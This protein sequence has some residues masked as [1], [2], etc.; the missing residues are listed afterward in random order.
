MRVLGKCL[1]TK[2]SLHGVWIVCAHR[3]VVFRCHRWNNVD[4]DVLCC[5]AC[6]AVLAITYLPGLSTFAADKVTCLYEQQL[7]SEHKESCPF[8]KD[9]LDY[10]Q[11]DVSVTIPRLFASYVPA[12]LVHL[13]ETTRPIRVFGAQV[14]GRVAQD[15][16]WDAVQLELHTSIRQYQPPAGADTAGSNLA[17]EDRLVKALGDEDY[18]FENI[19]PDKVKMAALTVLLGWKPKTSAFACELCHASVDICPADNETITTT[20]TEPPN[21]R[22]RSSSGWDPLYS[23]RHYCPYVCGFPRHG[24]SRA[25]PLWKALADKLLLPPKTTTTGASVGASTTELA[26]KSEW[27]Q[28][29]AMLNAAIVRSRKVV[30]SK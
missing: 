2:N 22:A 4:Q 23:H 24:A 30:D 1:H 28:V 16:V 15:L 25:T 11:H 9:A 6:Q 17:L 20:A 12:D 19:A 14:Q 13:V 27:V 5:D 18:N 3:V 29:N 8:R 21:K 10:F 7:G 26:G